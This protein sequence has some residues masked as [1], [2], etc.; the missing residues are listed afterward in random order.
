MQNFAQVTLLDALL[1]YYN[2]RENIL[3]LN[4]DSLKVW[5]E[6]SLESA[7]NSISEPLNLK[8]FWGSG[9]P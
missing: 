8:I 7:E 5:R 4:F 9:P 6:K 2:K 1:D 3:Y